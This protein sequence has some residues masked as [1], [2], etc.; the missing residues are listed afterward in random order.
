[1]ETPKETKRA[2]LARV[3]EASEYTGLSRAKL[4]QLMDVGKLAYVKI[5]KARRIP[6]ESLLE[7][8]EANTV[9]ATV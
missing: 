5:D 3:R 2:G 1:M 8:I 4:Y 9:R 7:L 6:W